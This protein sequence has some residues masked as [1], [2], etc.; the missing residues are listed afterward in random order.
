M[1]CT[2][3]TQLVVETKYRTKCN[4]CAD[5]I[6]LSGHGWVKGSGGQ[7][8]IRYFLFDLSILILDIQLISYY[9]QFLTRIG[10]PHGV[11]VIDSLINLSGPKMCFNLD[12]R[13]F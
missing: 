11:L 12:Y 5:H 1:C 9:T 7:P 3:V 8:L 6:G 4:K 2:S 13:E 10:L